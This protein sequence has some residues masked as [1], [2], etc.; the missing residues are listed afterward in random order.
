MYLAEWTVGFH[1]L[2][3]EKKHGIP[4]HRRMP[5]IQTPREMPEILHNYCMIDATDGS[6]TSI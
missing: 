6:Q 3:L 5:L 1:S 2:K 4:A